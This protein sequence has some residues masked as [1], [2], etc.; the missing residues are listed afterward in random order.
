MDDSCTTVKG[1]ETHRLAWVPDQDTAN[2][3]RQ[4]AEIKATQKPDEDLDHH[5]KARIR[6]FAASEG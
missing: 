3:K 5:Q 4:D 6:H 1:F 2:F